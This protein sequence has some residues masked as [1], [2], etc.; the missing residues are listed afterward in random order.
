MREK[1]GPLAIL[2][3]APGVIDDVQIGGIGREILPLDAAA[4]YI[5]EQ[6]L[7]FFV[8]TE[9]IPNDA[10]RSLEVTV[11]ALHKGNE[12]L[13]GDMG[14]LHGEIEAQAVLDRRDGDGADDREAIM[15]VP[16]VLDRGL[17]PRGPG[18]SNG[19]VK[20]EAGFIHEAEGSSLALGFF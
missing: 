19:G 13:T 12:V 14:R 1:I 18:L 11:Q 7:S 8:P 15:A 3:V 9:P 6:P 16:A 5:V 20:H 17:P 4:V 10:Q 2:R